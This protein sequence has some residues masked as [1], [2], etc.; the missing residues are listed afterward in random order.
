MKQEAPHSIDP[1]G[2]RKIRPIRVE[3]GISQQE[4]A[5]SPGITFQQLQKYE[6]GINRVSVSRS[7]QIAVYS[8]SSRITCCSPEGT[9]AKP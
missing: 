1:E 6:K 7:V 5:N 9:Y 4:V 8:M 2:G 3:R